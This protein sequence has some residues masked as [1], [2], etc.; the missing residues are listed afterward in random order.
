MK[1]SLFF[2][3]LLFLTIICQKTTDY[4]NEFYYQIRINDKFDALF[5]VDTSLSE[6]YFFTDSNKVNYNLILNHINDE[7]FKANIEINGLYID[8]FEFILTQDFTGL[9]NEQIQGIIG[10]GLND[11]EENN[12]ID[13]LKE[14][15]IIKNRTIYYQI[16]PE[17]KLM[18]PIEIKKKDMKNFT[19]CEVVFNEDY[20]ENWICEM[21]NIL[22]GDTV[23]KDS[24]LN[25]NN[26]INLDE[27]YAVFDLKSYY[28]TTSEKYINYF[29][30]KFNEFKANACTTTKIDSDKYLSCSFTENDLSILPYVAFVFDG[31]GYKIKGE[32]LF[33][34]MEKGK[35][36]SLIRFNNKI[37]DDVWVFG[38]PLFY[39]YLIKFD[40]D[41]LIVGFNGEEPINFTLFNNENLNDKNNN[42]NFLN[43]LIEM[44]KNLWK[45]K[46]SR[47][48]ILCGL[49]TII[50]AIIAYLIYRCY[51]RDNKGG[52]KKLI[53]EIPQNFEN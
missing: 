15:K 6:S 13:T 8:N 45:N 43:N 26:T 31:Y 33:M 22:F 47:Y 46:T 50:L 11:D 4:S 37:N 14:Q 52:M 18:F 27:N 30:K 25:L 17:P 5:L 29:I 24:N 40:F 21:T 7:S 2:L 23:K 53:E 39:S 38:Y 10:L 42:E 28:I 20:P 16:N 3:I 1:K 51:N 35:Y 36:I 49:G 41:N 9:E 32:N 34:N 12:L 48:S 44:C 19:T